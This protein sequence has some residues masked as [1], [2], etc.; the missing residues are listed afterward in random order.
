[1]RATCNADSTRD[2]LTLVCDGQPS[3]DG[4]LSATRSS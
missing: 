4:G 2:A 1:V 3:S